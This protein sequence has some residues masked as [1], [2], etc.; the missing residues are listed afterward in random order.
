ML[1]VRVPAAPTAERQHGVITSVAGGSAVNAARAAARLGVRAAVAGAV[2]DDTVGRVIELELEGGG[3]ETHLERIHA[4]ATGT[5]VYSREAVVADRGANGLYL[6]ERLPEARVTLVS[7]YLPADARRRALELAG[8][9][10]A[11]DLQGV[12]DDEPGAD[13]VI[14]PEVDLDALAA[15]HAV[16]CSTLAERGARAAR[17][18]ER[19]VAAPERVL[20]ASPIGAGD[21]FAAAFL[22]ALADELPLAEC[23]RRGCAAAVS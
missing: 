2:G 8:G 19:A 20:A 17:G 14:G 3:I 4:S 12:L 15:S 7:G 23:L 1:D 10:R 16:A 5:A 13:V 6:P 18:G 22:L 9:I 21:A 11:V